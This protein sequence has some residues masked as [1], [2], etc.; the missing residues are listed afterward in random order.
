MVVDTEVLKFSVYKV[1]N[2]RKS[3]IKH[4]FTKMCIKLKKKFQIYIQQAKCFT[5]MKKK[6][7]K[8][9]TYYKSHSGMGP[10]KFGVKRDSRAN[11]AYMYKTNFKSGVFHF[12]G[13][14]ENR[15]VLF[16]DIKRS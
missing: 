10:Q 13:K 1:R 7:E 12:V 16:H 8:R 3:T 6:E 9:N 14:I 15:A 11:H 2:C 5:E 4:F